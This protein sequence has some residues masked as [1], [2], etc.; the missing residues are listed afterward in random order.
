MTMGVP[1]IILGYF[2]SF[3][4][5]EFMHIVI[6]D[7]TVHENYQVDSRFY[8]NSPENATCFH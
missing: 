6:K 4:S 1:D 8:Y 5:E 7:F 3:E 2:T